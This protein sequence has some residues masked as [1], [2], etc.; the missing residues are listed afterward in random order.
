M[1][2]TNTDTNEMLKAILNSIDEGIHVI[3]QDG[4][5]IYYNKIA[6]DH[7]GLD[8]SDVIGKPLLNVFPSLSAETSTLIKVMKTGNPI[9]NQHQTYRNLKG[10]L[11][12]TVNT[13]I[14]IIVSGS[15]IGSVEIAK[16]MS[17]VR[18]LSLKLMDLQ[19][20]MDDRS[21]KALEVKDNH[22]SYEFDHILTC[23]P[24]ME[25]II[26]QGKKV[27][28]TT[29][30]VFVYGETGTGKELLVQA[31]HNHS[32]RRNRPFIS[33][34][35][36]AIPASL[37]ESILFG[38]VKGSFTGA[39]EREGFFEL[40][41][42]G[43]LFLDEI[44]T[45]PMD[46]QA[47]LLRVLEDGIIR[48]VGSNKSFSTDV[49]IIA[50]T[51]ENPSSLLSKNLLRPDLYYRLNVVSFHLP[52]LR[53]RRT[54]IPLLVDHFVSMYNFRFNKLVSGTDKQASE[55]LKHYNWPGNIRELRHA[56]EAA[57]NMTDEIISPDH[58]P[59]HIKPD[60]SENGCFFSGALKT[61]VENYEA[62]M[63]AKVLNE[64]GRNV[65]QTAKMLQ[66][67]RQTLQYKITKYNL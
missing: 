22:V 7:D 3:D 23:S 61:K 64:S 15:L 27:S 36:A 42:G 45:L 46:L 5:T 33:Q 8:V 10:K 25:S 29:S 44:Q 11:I 60:R 41:H 2:V 34:N 6:A 35:C 59:L 16:D 18:D 13:T 20:K 12:D 67:P 50:A 53:S 19:A 58:L 47:K 62:E 54:D 39:E 37:L 26:K 49:R 65:K 1:F 48:R 32:P 31:I 14:P 66:M 55:I 30:P 57:M 28:K 56:V 63:I 9:F 52:P 24:E 51:N 17:R 4:I 43:T 38:T 40:A 21:N